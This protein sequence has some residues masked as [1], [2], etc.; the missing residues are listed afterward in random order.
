MRPTWATKKGA[1]VNERFVPIAALEPMPNLSKQK[2]PMVLVKAGQNIT[3][4][5]KG[6]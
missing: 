4:T 6:V 1:K 5:P 3:E 2:V